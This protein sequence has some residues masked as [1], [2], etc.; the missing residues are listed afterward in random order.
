MNSKTESGTRSRVSA[1]RAS[2]DGDR[3]DHEQAGVDLPVVGHVPYRNIGFLAA[4]GVA[5]AA[6]VLDWPVAAA[7][8]VGYVLA[9]R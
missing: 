5:G 3:P 6:G 9:R 4:L 8:G 2:R 7:I 1:E